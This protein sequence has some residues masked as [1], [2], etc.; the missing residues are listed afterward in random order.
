VRFHRFLRGAKPALL[1]GYFM[2]LEA[3][4]KVRRLLAG[5]CIWM[6]ESCTSKCENGLVKRGGVHSSAARVEHLVGES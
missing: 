4:G 2:E 3:N 1:A 5:I 6:P